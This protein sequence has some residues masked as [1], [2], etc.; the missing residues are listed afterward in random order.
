MDS[1]T[2][3]EQEQDE[4]RSLSSQL[5]IAKQYQWVQP[6]AKASM[7]CFQFACVFLAHVV[8]VTC[9]IKSF[10]LESLHDRI[11]I[12][13]VP[14]K[15]HQ[16]F[17]SLARSISSVS[18]KTDSRSPPELALSDMAPCTLGLDMNASG[19]DDT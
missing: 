14:C 19:S 4:L 10:G 12:I 11:G 18:A 1:V 7:R 6:S 17:L 2:A 16:L 8:Q 5:E 3:C 9:A 15:E 13:L